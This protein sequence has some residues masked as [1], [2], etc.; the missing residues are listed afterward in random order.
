MQVLERKLRCNDST[1]NPTGEAR[2]EWSTIT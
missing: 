2:Q 1:V